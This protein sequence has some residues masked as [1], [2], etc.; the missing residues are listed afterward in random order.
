MI[1]PEEAGAVGALIALL[2][3]AAIARWIALIAGPESESVRQALLGLHAF[4][5]RLNLMCLPF[6]GFL[7]MIAGAFIAVSPRSPDA[8]KHFLGALLA[9]N[10]VLVVVT[11]IYAAIPTLLLPSFFYRT[12][13][14]AESAHRNSPS[15]DAWAVGA[16]SG[17]HPRESSVPASSSMVGELG[18]GPL[19]IPG[20][21][22]IGA[23]GVIV[24]CA[25]VLCYV[26]VTAATDELMRFLLSLA[27]ICAIIAVA[28]TGII[29][30]GVGVVIDREGIVDRTTWMPA[31]SLPWRLIEGFY[32]D[33]DH[34][35]VMLKK[36]HPDY[37]SLSVLERLRVMGVT[38]VVHLRTR[39]LDVDPLE[40]VGVLEWHSLLVAIPDGLSPEELDLEMRV[41]RDLF[42]MRMRAVHYRNYGIASGGP[43]DS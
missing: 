13:S 16:G 10:A 20:R 27:L 18:T 19:H 7:L 30:R 4:R 17:A 35:V 28:M 25:A 31:L 24:A 43:T 2:G 1:L 12:S 40:L 36:G 39:Y 15:Q 33:G 22:P 9:I 5:T 34:V 42:F 3:L 38:G 26:G 11:G 14:S 8:L 37:A 23:C 32:I 29:L 6:T 21:R 41:M